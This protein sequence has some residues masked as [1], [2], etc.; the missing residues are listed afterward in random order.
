MPLSVAS[1]EVRK[2]SYSVQL[3]TFFCRTVA[4]SHIVYKISVFNSQIYRCAAVLL[5]YC[6]VLRERVHQYAVLVQKREAE[7]QELKYALLSLLL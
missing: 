4:L 3:V 7:V 5:L 2:V 6:G 1:V